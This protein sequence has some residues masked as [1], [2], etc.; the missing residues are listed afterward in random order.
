MDRLDRRDSGLLVPVSRGTDSAL[1]YWL[2]KQVIPA[3]TQAVH[4]GD[5][6]PA[7]E[8][9][10]SLGSVETIPLPTGP[11]SRELGRWAMLSSLSMRRRVWLVGSRNRTKDVFGTFSLASRVATYYPIVG[12]WKTEVMELCQMVGVPQELIQSSRYPDIQCG[13]T[14]QMAEI[15]IEKIDQ[16]L[17]VKE[18]EMPVST[19]ADLGEDHRHYLE[20]TY[21]KGQFK[22]KPPIRAPRF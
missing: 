16:F 11:E 22:R 19:L 14:E 15:G 4:F 8:W 9:F 7:R 18:G 10:E 5:N 12:L 6:L 20:Q 21:R 17:K 13:R 1:C 3:K 2:C